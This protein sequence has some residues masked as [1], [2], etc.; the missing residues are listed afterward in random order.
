MEKEN[1]ISTKNVEDVTDDMYSILWENEQEIPFETNNYFLKTQNEEKDISPCE[2]MISPKQIEK[3][4][5]ELNEL[6]LKT[7]NKIIG[8]NK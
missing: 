4:E 1:Q 2:C 8:L 7:K 5:N 6:R 3:R